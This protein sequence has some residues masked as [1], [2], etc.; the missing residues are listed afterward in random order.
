MYRPAMTNTRHRAREETATAGDCGRYAGFEK[1]AARVG[2]INKHDDALRGLVAA[3]GR[4]SATGTGVRP[5]EQAQCSPFVGDAMY[6]VGLPNVWAVAAVI[7][8][9]R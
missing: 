9:H 6:S 7:G 8:G 1:R 2:R 4:L 3:G 5:F